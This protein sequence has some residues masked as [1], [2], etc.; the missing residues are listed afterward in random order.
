MRPCAHEPPPHNVFCGLL[1]SGNGRRKQRE[2]KEARL[3]LVEG[4]SGRF[5]KAWG[6]RGRG[7]GKELEALLERMV[8]MVSTKAMKGF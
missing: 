8:E 3:Q 2:K 4:Q 1:S 7:G 6:G 5:Q